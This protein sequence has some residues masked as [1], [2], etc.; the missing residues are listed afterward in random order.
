MVTPNAA[1]PR[2]KLPDGYRAIPIS[3]AD[4]DAPLRLCA[5]VRQTPDP[6]AGHFVTL[7]DLH[8]ALVYLGCIVDA[9]GTVFDWIE[10]AVQNVDGLAGSLPTNREAFSNHSLNERWKAAADHRRR[11]SPDLFVSTGWESKHPL[12][13]FLDLGAG[14]PRRYR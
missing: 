1:E 4:Q 12:P 11:L 2:R 14:L 5:V 7:A 9:A 6:A 13:C 3:K 10:I 8:D